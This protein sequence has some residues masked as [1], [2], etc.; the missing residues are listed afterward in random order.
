M[1][2][3]YAVGSRCLDRRKRLFGIPLGIL[4][5]MQRASILDYFPQGLRAFRT[6]SARVL[7]RNSRY[8]GPSL[9]YLGW[10]A[11]ANLLRTNRRGFL[12]AVPVLHTAGLGSRLGDR[13]PDI[14]E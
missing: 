12:G 13:S 10:F 7:G 9:F 11:G 14:Y 5:A 4:S 6:I 8:L 1:A 3:D 2:G